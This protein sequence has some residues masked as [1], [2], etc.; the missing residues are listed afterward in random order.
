MN[1]FELATR[2]AYRFESTK[3]LLSVE[4]LWQLPL[5]TRGNGTSLDDVAKNVYAQIKASEEVSFVAKQT[6]ANTTL[7]NKLEIVK[8]IIAVKMNE[9]DV[10]KVK[11]DKAAERAKLMDIL[12]RKQEQSLENSTEEEL[13]AK[14]AAIDEN[15]G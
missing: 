11:A 14:L 1:L 9:A 12:A 7:S 3:G 10:A 15:L 8:H 5:T 13:L 4:D 2:Q 6:T